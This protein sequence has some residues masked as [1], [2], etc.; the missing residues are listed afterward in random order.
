MKFYPTKIEVGNL[1]KHSF[2]LHLD[3][4]YGNAGLGRSRQTT[5]HGTK[6]VVTWIWS[7]Y[8]NGETVV[9]ATWK[10]GVGTELIGYAGQKA[11]MRKWARTRTRGN[12][13]TA[14]WNWVP[15]TYTKD[16]NTKTWTTRKANKNGRTRR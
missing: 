8:L 15:Y 10:E 13:M 2:S 6:M 12:M 3:H 14:T 11:A 4:V 7:L 1:D 9:V 5:G 16:Q